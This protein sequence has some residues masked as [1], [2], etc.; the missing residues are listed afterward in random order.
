[1]NWIV[2]AL[3]IILILFGLYEIAHG[4]RQSR[5]HNLRFL[6]IGGLLTGL[7]FLAAGTILLFSLDRPVGNWKYL[8]FAAWVFGMLWETWQRRKYYRSN[9][10][11]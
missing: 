9:P 6:L 1:V 2:T 5:R 7:P 3:T 10:R 11:E 4:Y 8:V